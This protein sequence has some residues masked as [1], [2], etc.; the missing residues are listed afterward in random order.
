V[1]GTTMLFLVVPLWQISREGVHLHVAIWLLPSAFTIALPFGICLGL[2]LAPKDRD[3][4]ASR[5]AAVSVAVAC[6]LATFALLQWVLPDSNQTFRVAYADHAFSVTVK[7]PI[8]LRRGSGE[9]SL[10]ELAV[11]AHR[12]PFADERNV[13]RAELYLR[14]TLVVAPIAL[15]LFLLEI[16]RRMRFPRFT[17]ISLITACYVCMAY[18][19]EWMGNSP[20]WMFTIAWA[21]TLLLLVVTVAFR[22]RESNR[23]RTTARCP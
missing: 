6:S 16:V 19:R 17:G 5:V 21:P 13:A 3:T 4:I 20:S 7:R 18:Q 14:L 11:D 23:I 15:T 9:R 22:H 10:T 8:A 1:I 12:A 2:T